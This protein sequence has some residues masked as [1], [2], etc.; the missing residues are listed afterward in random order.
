MA[1][2]AL[3]WSCLTG[4]KLPTGLRYGLVIFR[5]SD[6][7][8]R[9]SSP[10]SGDRGQFYFSVN[11]HVISV[12]FLYR[13]I[14]PRMIVINFY[15]QLSAGIVE[16]GR[17]SR[18]SSIYRMNVQIIYF[19]AASSQLLIRK[20]GNLSAVPKNKAGF[21][22]RTYS[23]I[24]VQRYLQDVKVVGFRTGIRSSVPIQ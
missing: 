14:L 10:W 24:A 18:V 1:V 17:L 3:W 23:D 8:V 7:I 6:C 5:R 15:F 13:S 21:I 2:V 4:M 11:F 22:L 12:A 19:D 16:K 20:K 9:L